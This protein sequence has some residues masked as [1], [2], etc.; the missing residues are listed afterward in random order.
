[1][2]I[3]FYA[4]FEGLFP[5]HNLA[6][7]CALN[8]FAKEFN[9]IV[10]IGVENRGSWRFLRTKAPP[11]GGPAGILARDRAKGIRK[12]NIMNVINKLYYYPEK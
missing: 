9:I 12:L 10:A 1:L 2:S 4:L 7:K 3:A 8:L 5:G 6:V 11:D